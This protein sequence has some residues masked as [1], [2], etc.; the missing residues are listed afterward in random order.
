[1]VCARVF[2]AALS[3]VSVRRAV[4]NSLDIFKFSDLGYCGDKS[5]IEPIFASITASTRSVLASLPVASANRLAC[6]GFTFA[7]GCLCLAN[8]ASRLQ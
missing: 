7:K 1:M 2:A 6:R 8:V 5:R 4:S 3:F